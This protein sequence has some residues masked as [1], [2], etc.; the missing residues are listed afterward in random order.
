MVLM[1]GGPLTS[2]SSA[3][4]SGNGAGGGG[5][6]G[7]GEGG[8]GGRKGKSGGRSGG[9]NTASTSGEWESLEHIVS[10]GHSF[11]RLLSDD[12]LLV[13]CVFAVA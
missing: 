10:S 5:T 2:P 3:A 8:K 9:K 13:E 1:E 12:M 11:F 7:R 6:G 4:P